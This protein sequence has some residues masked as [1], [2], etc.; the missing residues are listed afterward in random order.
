[1]RTACLAAFAFAIS[2]ICLSAQDVQVNAG[3]YHNCGLTGT[4]RAE[5]VVELNKLKNRATAPTSDDIHP[6]IDAAWIMQ[7]SKDDTDRFDVHA[8]ATIRLYVTDVKVGGVETVN[9][10]ATDPKYRDTHIEGN[11]E[12]PD[13]SGQPMI[14]EV[15]PRWR[16]AMVAAGTDWS[17][18]QLK[19]DLVGNWVE[20]TGWMME[21]EEHRGSAENTVDTVRHRPGTT[22][23][24]WRQTTWEIHPV[25]SMQIVT[26]PR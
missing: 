5:R 22:P 3:T 9:C 19:S 15:T 16:A 23:N 13:Y 6:D 10:G 25:T 1:M 12:G 8:G 11:A 20:F 4:A 2:P 17:T 18:D 14:V 21:D 7:P 24:I 26:G